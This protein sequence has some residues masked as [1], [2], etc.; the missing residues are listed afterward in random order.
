M[1]IAHRRAALAD[2]VTKPQQTRVFAGFESMVSVTL[3]CRSRSLSDVYVRYEGEDSYM[4]MI[5]TAS[6]Y[7]RAVVVA[8]SV[9]ALGSVFAGSAASAAS[10]R[11]PRPAQKAQKTQKA[12]KVALTN[13][14][15]T[16]A[17]HCVAIGRIGTAA[18][19]PSLAE[20]WNGSHWRRIASPGVQGPVGLDCLG[21]AF[22]LVGGNDSAA[23]RT[24]TSI[25]N[26]QR[27]KVTPSAEV[28]SFIRLTCVNKK[29]CVDVG[30]GGDVLRWDGSAWHTFQAVPEPSGDTDFGL[31]GISC[32]S[33]KFCLAVGFATTDDDAQIEQA[34]AE[35]WNGTFLAA[36]QPAR[37]Q[38][39]E[40][41]QR[42]VLHRTDPLH[43]RRLSHHPE[44]E[45]GHLQRYQHRGSMGREDLARHSLA[46]QGRRRLR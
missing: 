45:A 42:R 22:C 13:I 40:H 38:P 43:G 21:S 23:G 39:R 37:A 20:S 6:K 10:V 44:E 31:S 19:P 3:F 11:A 24:D 26:G 32:T 35:M 34:V 7:A 25:W 18:F 41:L 4:T 14:S 9:L 1:D 46:R 5:G 8:A 2:P 29:F 15:C 33:V 30:F 16:S 12:Q 28:P 17:K 36:R 27:W